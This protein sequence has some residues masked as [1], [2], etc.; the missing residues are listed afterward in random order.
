MTARWILLFGAPVY[1][2]LAIFSPTVLGAMGGGFAE[3]R[4]AMVILCLGSIGLLA[5]GNVQ[6][7]LLMSGRSSWAAFNKSI[8]LTFNVVGNLV[9][10]PRLGITGSALTWALTMCL[11]TT[12]AVWQTKRATGV[13]IDGWQVLRTFALVVVAVAGPAGV[14][15]LVWGQGIWQMSV[16]AVTAAAGLGAMCYLDRR[17]LQLTE[18]RGIRRVRSTPSP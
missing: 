2:G 8:S 12:L 13:R 4:A 16:A 17:R 14:V 11:D 6:S 5:A 9:T 15:A 10:I 7:L 18:L 3:G 1:L